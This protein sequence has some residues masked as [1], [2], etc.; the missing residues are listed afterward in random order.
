[1]KTKTKIRISLI[2][3]V[4][5][6]SAGLFY[7]AVGTPFTAEPQPISVAAA[8]NQLIVSVFCTGNLAK[9]SDTGVVTPFASIP[10]PNVG[11][12]ERYLAISPALGTWTPGFVYATQ[13]NEIYKFAPDG[14]SVSLFATV[15]NCSGSH[16]GIT[17]DHFGTNF[18]FDMIVTCEDG[19]VA[20]IDPAGVVTHVATVP[21]GRELEGPAVVPAG[22]GPEGGKIWAAD[23]TGG[24]IITISNTGV[25]NTSI[26]TWPGA[27]SILVI[28]PNPC[29]FGNSDGA[30]FSANYNAN[31]ITKFT[32]GDLSGLGGNVLVTSEGGQGIL[33][34]GFNGTSYTGATFENPPT[35]YEG[36]AITDCL[37]V[38]SPTPTPTATATAT[39][40]ATPTAT[41]TATATPTS[42]PTSTPTP[43]PT[44][45]VTPGSCGSSF[46]IGDLD[47]VVGHHVTFWG[48]QWWRL[49]H[50][51]G[52]TAPAS[53]K[54]FANCTNPNPPACGG[55]WQSDP[56]NSSHPPAT[57]PADMTVIVSSL[58]TKSGPIESGDIPMMVT[59][60][61]D[62]GYEPNPGHA[63]TGTVTA[64]VCGAAHP[65]R[66]RGDRVHR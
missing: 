58:I 40:T 36:S 5:F 48:A 55:T 7:A 33:L 46:V 56:G 59:I 64:V 49:N 30:M 19:E 51:S 63:G 16:S 57:V 17:F 8:P 52:G 6:A 45:T 12:V 26:G 20:R 2:T 24:N 35:S 62:P 23:E 32:T 27:E 41:A 61:T 53:F 66:P 38:P 42:T 28:P 65:Q 34:I 25:V 54:G 10:G 21:A 43:T 14:S 1:M 18:N 11:C 22:F 47:A 13:V 4:L 37:V 15:P 44:P 3:L 39:A 29:S 50:L 31:N 60:H 9:V